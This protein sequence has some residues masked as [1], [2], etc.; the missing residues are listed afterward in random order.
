ATAR[1]GRKSAGHDHIK[2]EMMFSDLE[3]E[4]YSRQFRLPG[5]GVAG[6]A[7]LKSSRVLLVGAGG[8]GC[9]VGLY[10]AAAGIGSIGIADGDTVERSNLHRQVAHSTRT[11]GQPKV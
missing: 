5:F 9:P 1:H 10:L 6:Q 2:G 3:K 11:L 7:R 4:Q 8:L